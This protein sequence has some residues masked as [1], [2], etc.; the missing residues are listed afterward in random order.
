MDLIDAALRCDKPEGRFA[1]VAPTYTQAK[2]VAWAYLKRFTA[3]LPGVEQKETELSVVL[4]NGARIRLYGADNYDRMRGL[5]FDGVVLDEYGDMDPRA[6]PEVVRP[7]LADRQGWAT[8]IGTP[9]G[10]NAFHR[11]WTR[12]QS[13]PDWYTAALKASE[14]GLVQ[15]EELDSLRKI[16]TPEQYDQEMEV[17]FDAAIVGAYYGRQMSDAELEKRITGIPHEPVAQVYSAWD[18][19]VSDHTAIWF[20][21]IVGREI[22]LID[23]YEATGQGADHYV[24]VL[25]AKPYIYAGHLV[26]HDAQAR[27]FGTGKT[28]TEVMQSLGLNPI[29]A[30]PMHRVEEGING[31]RSILSRCWFDA[32]KCAHGIE[33]LKMYRAEWDDKNQ[34]LKPKPVHDYAS[35]GADAFRYLAMGLDYYAGVQVEKRAIDRYRPRSDEDDTSWMAA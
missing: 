27:E 29:L 35:H 25:R 16:L 34:T 19:G 28:P 8:F 3:S 7:A 17:S 23:Y 30:V 31:V 9:K 6:F 33:C 5:Y 10:R 13:D 14:T 20:A 15:Q 12:A 24:S 4:H 21:Q 2:D 11:V 26:P 1:Y 32:T 18:L 22:R